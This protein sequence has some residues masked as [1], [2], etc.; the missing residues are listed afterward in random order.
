VV[1]KEGEDMLVAQGELTTHLEGAQVRGGNRQENTTLS[2]YLLPRIGDLP[3][4][5]KSHGEA[6][7]ADGT[8][9]CQA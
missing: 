4:G 8:I 7:T 3:G 5:I 9:C 6:A 2:K 1:E